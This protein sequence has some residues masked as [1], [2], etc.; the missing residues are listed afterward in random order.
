[1]CT[2]L[3]FGESH[4]HPDLPSVSCRKLPFIQAA[5]KLIGALLRQ[6]KMMLFHLQKMLWK[7]IW[8]GKWHC[9][10]EEEK[11]TTEKMLEGPTSKHLCS[12]SRDKCSAQHLPPRAR[13][14]TKLLHSI[15]LT[16]S[17]T[18]AWAPDIPAIYWLN[19]V[20][21]GEKMLICKHARVEHLQHQPAWCSPPATG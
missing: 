13:G 18:L 20:S 15:Q 4:K 8:S 14:T 16:L 17:G 3:L 10:F 11:N 7:L 6:R 1:M 21:G 9:Y 2:S 5:G 19:T 12:Y